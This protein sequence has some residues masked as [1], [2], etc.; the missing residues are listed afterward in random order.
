MTPTPL[1]VLGLL[2]IAH[3]GPDDHPHNTVSIEVR[4]DYR[5]IAANGIPDHTPG[6]FPNRGNPNTISEQTYSWRVPLHPKVNDGPPSFAGGMPFGVALNGVPFDPGTAELWRN[7]PDWRYE[8][9]TGPLNLGID[10]HHAHV[11]PTGAYHY[12][13]LPTGFIE[14]RGGIK[15]FLLIGY[16]ADGFPIYGPYAFK[17][18]D[19]ADSGLVK[20]K[21]SWRV[22]D[23]A[24]PAGAPSGKYDGSFVADWEYVEGLGDLDMC[25][26]R[27][28]VTPEYPE[29]TY[30]YVLTE[31]YP[32]V[33]RYFKG[34]PDDSFRRRG[35]GPGGPGGR[36]GPD[37]RQGPPPPRDGRRPPPPQ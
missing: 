17:D 18:A 28:G 32:F 12:H 3:A 5:Y 25:N 14:A 29:G 31:D 35:P 9:L 13:G 7:D 30:Y 16:A 34:T 15:Q 20:L 4:G 21:P 10:Q 37:A 27:F 19:D 2:L 22:K 36:G 23:G 1:T 8:A 6:D 26:G 11:Q 24:R 33:P